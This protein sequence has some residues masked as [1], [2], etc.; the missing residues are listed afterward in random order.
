MD[1]AKQGNCRGGDADLFFPGRGG[2]TRAARAICGEC[3]VVAECR[4]Y[5]VRT[6]QAYGVWGNTSERQRRRLRKDA[7]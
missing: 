3:P 4:D 5:A 2:S 7:N 6:K 1:W